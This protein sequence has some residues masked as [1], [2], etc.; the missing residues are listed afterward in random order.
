MAHDV[1]EHCRIDPRR[2]SVH[3]LDIANAFLHLA[4][5]S[6][7]YCW[8]AGARPDHPINGRGSL[9]RFNA[10]KRFAKA[11]W[12]F[13]DLPQKGFRHSLHQAP[14]IARKTWRKLM[15]R[16]LA[17]AAFALA[18]ATSTQAMTPAPINQPDGMITQV[19][20]GCGPGRT[21]VG[22]VCVA[23]PPSAMCAD[24]PAG[25]RDGTEVFALGGFTETPGGIQLP[26]LRSGPEELLALRPD[27]FVAISPA[28]AVAAHRATSIVPIVMWGVGEPMALG[29][30]DSLAH[31][32][33]NVTGTSTMSDESRQVGR[34]P[35]R[36]TAAAKLAIDCQVE[37]A[38][39]R[40]GPRSG[41]LS[42]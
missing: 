41:A 26:F 24:K 30:V 38:R 35:S 9:C 32:G 15:I 16:F 1:Q 20:F 25:V 2:R 39:S 34:N 33:G 29:L 28:A 3:C 36:G 27:V 22:G 10:E 18:V 13:F 5:L 42:D 23:R 7:F 8:Q 14:Q 4:P 37:H 11:F 19:A 40:R 31:P 17:F 21:R 6:S 12:N